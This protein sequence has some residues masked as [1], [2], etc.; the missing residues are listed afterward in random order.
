M[1]GPEN[2]DEPV[3]SLVG[4][5]PMARQRRLVLVAGIFLFVT[6]ATR[7]RVQTPLAQRASELLKPIQVELTL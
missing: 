7:S 2:S 1:T 6:F 4:L 5:P 3:I